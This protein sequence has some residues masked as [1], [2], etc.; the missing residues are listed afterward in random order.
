MLFESTCSIL[1]TW[2]H[3]NV[4]KRSTYS[5]RETFSLSKISLKSTWKAL[6]LSTDGSAT[7]EWRE[8]SSSTLILSA[9]NESLSCKSVMK[10]S[11]YFTCKCLFQFLIKE[12]TRSLIG[13]NLQVSNSVITFEDASDY[14]VNLCFNVWITVSYSILFFNIILH[15]ILSDWAIMLSYPSMWSDGIP[16]ILLTFCKCSIM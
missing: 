11:I 6:S 16:T 9:A 2:L 15:M 12:C 5:T 8:F 14:V 4:F 1:F 13:L 7:W 10:F 3:L